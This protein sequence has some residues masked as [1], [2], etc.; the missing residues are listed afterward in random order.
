ML[1]H[2]RLFPTP[3]TIACQAPPSMGF[4]R[5]EYWSG[6]PRPPPEDLSDTGIEP[7]SPVCPILADGFFTTE[8]RGK[9]TLRGDNPGGLI[10]KNKVREGSWHLNTYLFSI[11]HCCSN[12]QFV[13]ILLITVTI[14]PKQYSTNASEL[15]FQ[16]RAHLCH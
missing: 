6:L 13:W 5:Q 11:P 7:T 12:K 15:M 1:S 9:L 10:S 4:S 8:P 3:W 14:Y 16:G 2:V